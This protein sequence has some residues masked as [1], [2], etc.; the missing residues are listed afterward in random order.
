[1]S[2]PFIHKSI[3]PVRPLIAHDL[4]TYICESMRIWAEIYQHG[5]QDQTRNLGA[6]A[7][8]AIDQM[9]RHPDGKMR[10][11]VMDDFLGAIRDTMNAQIKSPAQSASGPHPASSSQH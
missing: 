8:V 1:M 4:T 7:A 9:L 6:L 2:S 11:E 5:V 3:Q 10:L